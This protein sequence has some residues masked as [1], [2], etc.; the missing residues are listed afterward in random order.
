MTQVGVAAAA[1][2]FGPHHEPAA[3]RFQN[4]CTLSHGLQ[5]AGPSRTGIKLGLGVEERLATTDT[6]IDAVLLRIPVCARKRALGAFPA[7]DA[8]L[9]IG[10]ES[11]PLLIRLYDLV[12]HETFLRAG[13]LIR[14][15]SRRRGST[16][17][18]F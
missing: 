2:D 16:G 18:S 3:I 5:E 4:S 13:W 10:Q 14:R 9:L 17:I 1:D 7:G 11:P 15:G 6:L 12:A 8:I